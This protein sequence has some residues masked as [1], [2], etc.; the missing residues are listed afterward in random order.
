MFV[1]TLPHCH[2]REEGVLSKHSAALAEAKKAEARLAERFRQAGTAQQ[3]AEGEKAEEA[4]NLFNVT[5][6][7]ASES[8]VNLIIPAL[9]SMM[10]KLTALVNWAKEH[11]GVIKAVFIGIAAGVAL[12]NA[13][14]LIALP[15]VIMTWAANL[16]GAIASNI[17]MIAVAVSAAAMWLAIIWPV[18]LVVAAVAA[19]IAV[20]VKLYNKF[21]GFRNVV[22]AVFGFV[23][24]VFSEVGAVCAKVF[25]VIMAAFEALWSQWSFD[26]KK[27]GAAWGDLWAKV[28]D[29][30]N[31]AFV[32]ISFV[33]MKIAWALQDA[34]RS[35][36]DGI[37]V[38]FAK[39]IA[40]YVAI[41]HGLLA[42]GK[43]VWEGLKT[44]AMAPLHWIEQ[45]LKAVAAVIKKVMGM[46]HK[47][48]VTATVA[49]AAHLPAPAASPTQKP[50]V[51]V[52]STEH[53]S[54]PANRV[55]Q[56]AKQPTEAARK[57]DDV[58]ARLVKF[59]NDWKAYEDKHKPSGGVPAILDAHKAAQAA[60]VKSA[61][62]TNN[63]H[64]ETSI[65]TIN[66]NTQA[67]DANGIAKD[68]GGAVKSHSLVSHA[69]GGMV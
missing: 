57:E 31:E 22:D 21:E 53:P 43:A 26:T 39:Y 2:R 18:A 33:A 58:A 51:P 10:G 19:V 27:I 35:A 3:A 30:I 28:A 66:V 50:P 41:W 42:A 17:A 44:A 37:K 56:P 69:D 14:F 46:F 54:H 55:G 45:K 62:V 6:K 64:K 13:E 1:H 59:Q 8:L 16:A 12:M 67:T 48:A 68:I 63:N 7:H 36:M 61:P 9:T 15:H 52:T 34:F 5:L 20:L 60:T 29:L 23:K 11:S 25:G 38:L 24:D 32:L 49:V 47:T 65:G 40:V 4:M